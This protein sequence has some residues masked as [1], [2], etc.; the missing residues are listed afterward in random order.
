MNVSTLT[1]A[2]AKVSEELT[3]PV[4][5]GSAADR[6][7]AQLRERIVS[8]D[9]LPDTVLSRAE[10]AREHGVSQSPVREAILKLEQEGLVA[11][12]PQSRTVVTRINVRHARETQFLRLSVELEVARTLCA[13]RDQELLLPSSRI[14]RMQKITGE[15]GD[16]SEFAAL[17]R[18]FHL[19]LFRAAGVASLWHMIS[20][21]T[22][23]IDR[24]RRLNLPDPGKIASV[25]NAHDLILSAIG[26]GD[27]DAVERHVRDHLSGTLESLPAMME[28][29]PE[30]FENAESPSKG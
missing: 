5:Y 1:E 10:L 14:L 19:S 9:L 6:V 3:G 28:A 27:F 24:L 2:L 8:L 20:G 15:D 26:A 18:L 21:R 13:R 23:H 4:Q 7:H 22:G 29:R 17:D 16:I 25:L 12:Y 30:F 11:S